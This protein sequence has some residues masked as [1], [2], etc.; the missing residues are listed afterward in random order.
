MLFKAGAAEIHLAISSPPVKFPDF[1]GINT[2][3][4]S[5]LIA[6]RMSVEQIREY[7]GAT[8]MNYLSLDGMIGATGRPASRFNTS[9]FTG[10]YP[11]PIGSRAASLKDE[12]P[13]RIAIMASGEG[14][15]A[16]AVIRA[17]AADEILGQVSLVIASR[18]EAGVLN[19]VKRLNAELGL[20]IKTAIIGKKTHPPEP[21]ESV[22]AGQQSQS[23]EAAIRK[24][25]KKEKIDL[26]LLLG[27]MRAIGPKLVHEYGWRSDFFDVFQARMLNT[28]PGLLP[29]TAGLWGIHV[30]KKVLASKLPHTGQTLHVVSADY[31]DGPMV[32]EHRI[33]VEPGETAEALSERVQ[34]LE[35]QN[36]V[37]DVNAFIIERKKFLTRGGNSFV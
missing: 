36:L 5:E 23:E 18:A 29:D 27:Y 3:D 14:T 17:Y 31:D 33:A 10:K 30:Q 37:I 4:V 9:C 1:Y 15:T 32:A 20:S 13:A 24:L 22:A 35:K 34:R 6:T 8:S 25:L 16:E 12:E 11:I 26:V 21:N 2:P 28:H 7:T 19:R